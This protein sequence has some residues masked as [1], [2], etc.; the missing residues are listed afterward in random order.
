[1]CLGGRFSFSGCFVLG[2]SKIHAISDEIPWENPQKSI[3]VRVYQLFL[4]EL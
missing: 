2:I 3:M 1:M 4:C